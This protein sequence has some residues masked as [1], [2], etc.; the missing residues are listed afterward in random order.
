MADV[1]EKK[2]GDLTVQI[3]RAEEDLDRLRDEAEQKRAEV[4]AAA[5]E[6]KRMD[7]LWQRRRD[8]QRRIERRREQAAMDE[9]AA[10]RFFAVRYESG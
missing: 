6:T 3:D 7:L 5:R 8:R 2:I 4:L 10:R 9:S 1:V